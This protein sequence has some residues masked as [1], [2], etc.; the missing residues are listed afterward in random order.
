M[1]KYSAKRKKQ[2]VALIFTLFVSV[3]VMAMA[4]SYL[5]MTISGQK[6]A[7]AY[8]QEAAALS[9][10]QVGGD[11]VISS[12]SNTAYWNNV[13]RIDVFQGVNNQIIL[14][15]PENFGNM[16]NPQALNADRAELADI[17][18]WFETFLTLDDF[19]RCYTAGPIPLR[20]GESE[21]FGYLIIVV[22]PELNDDGM[23][24]VDDIRIPRGGDISGD[25]Y[26]VG[27]MSFIFNTNEERVLTIA[28]VF[29]DPNFVSSRA[30]QLIVS[31]K[32][33]GG[34][35]ENTVSA[36]FP[37]SPHSSQG[38]F[39]YPSWAEFTADAAFIDENTVWNSDLVVDGANPVTG[40][41]APSENIDQILENEDTA[42][43]R[44][45]LN[46][47]LRGEQVDVSGIVK[48]STL[49]NAG[50]IEDKDGL[51]NEILPEFREMLSVN[52]PDGLVYSDLR[53]NTKFN[54]DSKTDNALINSMSGDSN[55][56][57]YQQDMGKT[58]TTDTIWGSGD[59]SLMSGVTNT[60]QASPGL[61]NK[62]AQGKTRADGVFVFNQDDYRPDPMYANEK[63]EVP[64]L[65]ITIGQ[66]EQNG[67]VDDVYTIE[68]VNYD[69]DGRNW[70]ENAVGIATITNTNLQ[71]NNNGVLYVSGANV[72]VSGIA[73]K[74]VSIVSDVN[75]EI[76]AAN[77]QAIHNSSQPGDMFDDRL[78]A[79]N[80][81]EGDN[82]YRYVDM[83]PE[84]ELD[85]QTGL[86][87][88]TGRWELSDAT[89]ASNGDSTAQ[90]NEHISQVTEDWGR[91]T[92]YRFPTYDAETEQPSG[93]IT[94]IGDLVQA[95]G[96]NPSIGIIASNRVLLNDFSQNPNSD[97][98]ARK[99]R[100][101]AENTANQRLT[102]TKKDIATGEG[103]GVLNVEAVIA[104]R[105]YNM[106]FDFN[107]SSKNLKYSENNDLFELN[108]GYAPGD[109]P[110]ANNAPAL[111][112]ANASHGN[113]GLLMSQS[114][115]HALGRDN[116]NNL[117]AA[118]GTENGDLYF[119][120]QYTDMLPQQA[121]KKL[122][123][124][125]FMGAIRPGDTSNIQGDISSFG[126]GGSILNFRGMIISRFADINADAGSG[127][128]DDGNRLDQLGYIFQLINVDHNLFS[129][130]PPLFTMAKRRSESDR[131]ARWR[132]LTYID[133]GAVN[134]NDMAD[135][136][137]D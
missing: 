26:R 49:N 75:P 33:V 116:N 21:Q 66:K 4:T 15:L 132:V 5:G 22:T 124:D 40:W 91:S 73:S 59:A 113:F 29:N 105:S 87:A 99:D 112:R 82:Q 96:T 61:Y 28:N 78:N 41:G 108:S 122:W 134:S 104:A 129:S 20:Y 67:T 1:K 17:R 10:A 69:W 51:N 97:Y 62:L 12:M 14:P 126:N 32:E 83:Q 128:D 117:I 115:A 16:D 37:N 38:E 85:P 133:Q 39:G 103:D 101:S 123:D 31:D 65:R 86:P 84:V 7:R 23:I 63:M 53:T 110:V 95:Q 45:T 6:A 24:K 107:N 30:I 57:T 3:L 93:N 109:A 98:S 64:T 52:K 77:W 74:S 60:G 131:I 9:L 111:D 79:P 130:S 114:L 89:P 42:S 13:N 81:L 88:L 46:A 8:T 11:A 94:I 27:V 80:V 121:R 43:K 50:P 47:Y 118:G 68:Q 137:V 71:E 120:N 76:E 72:Q 56:F 19:S 36:A 102:E 100:S 54:L 58:R 70:Q 135:A 127:R 34:I 25:G 55:N 90:S 44:Q 136:S 125:T 18:P 106:A 35:Y 48:M 2:G 92:A 119:V